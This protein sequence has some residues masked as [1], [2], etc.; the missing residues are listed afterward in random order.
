MRA[1]A[2]ASIAFLTLTG[3][4]YKA[5]GLEDLKGLSVQPLGQQQNLSPAEAL[6]V[7]PIKDNRG[8]IVYSQPFCLAIRAASTRFL[9]SSLLTASDT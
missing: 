9:A 7:T 4:V 5:Y 3:I 1:E 2:S 8:R 6:S